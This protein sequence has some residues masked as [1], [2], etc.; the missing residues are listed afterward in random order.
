MSAARR[1]ASARLE[2]K[3]NRRLDA[4]AALDRVRE[5]L[6]ATVQIVVAATIAYFISHDLL[7]HSSPA[8]AVTVTISILGF[9]RDAR[10]R[11]VLD[12]AVGITLGIVL[13]EIALIVIGVGWWQ[14]A[15]VLGITLLVSRLVSPSVPFAIAAAVQSMLVLLMPP[16]EGG[17][18]LRSIDAVVAGAVALTVTALIPRDPR[19]IADRDA[20][21]MVSALLESLDSV[22]AALR[23][24][25]EPAASLALE[26]LRR[27][28]KH[29]DAWNES[30]DSALAIARISPFLRRH[31]GALRHQAQVLGG[32]DLA[33]RHLRVI[34]RRISFLVRDGQQRPV[35]AELFESIRAGIDTLG[36]S[37]RKPE[38]ATDARAQ[39]A[40][41]MP[42]LDP[43]VTLPGAAFNTS[44]V[45][46]LLRP[47]LVD[48]LVATGMP[49]A[50]ARALLPPA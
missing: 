47:L 8:I 31:L 16:P 5:S 33:A 21:R 1:D 43:A 10:P 15:V 46:H 45:V 14:L 19:R 30:L 49:A 28:Q 11:R 18:F 27:T 25:H 3:L 41:I 40:A 29:L 12:S 4:R 44:I 50:E 13:S 39:F 48:L 37:L 7:G 6:P 9:S 26:R 35:L 34:T 32:L 23:E 42:L 2:R 22:A 24:A 20:R 36:Q 17:V 38:L